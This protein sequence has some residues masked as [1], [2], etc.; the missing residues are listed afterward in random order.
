MKMP[1]TMFKVAHHVDGG[2]VVSAEVDHL[3]IKK[4][5]KVRTETSR[6]IMRAKHRIKEMFYADIEARENSL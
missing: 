6:G 5:Y 1:G 4:T 3:G 2:L